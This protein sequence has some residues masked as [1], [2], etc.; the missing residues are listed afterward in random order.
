MV[1]KLSARVRV[2]VLG[3]LRQWGRGGA[4]LKQGR[5]RQRSLL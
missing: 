4:G 2:F 5:W 3:F 1:L